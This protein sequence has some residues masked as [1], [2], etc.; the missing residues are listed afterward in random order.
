MKRGSSNPAIRPGENPDSLAYWLG[1]EFHGAQPSSARDSSGQSWSV[2]YSY[3]DGTSKVV[4]VEPP[5]ADLS[6][7]YGTRS[8]LNVDGANGDVVMLTVNGQTA[9]DRALL[10]EARAKIEPIPLDVT[11]SG[12]N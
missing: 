2:S 6:D 1:S 10:Q 4:T 7:N 11:A 8:H 5:D 12:C 3:L 9:E